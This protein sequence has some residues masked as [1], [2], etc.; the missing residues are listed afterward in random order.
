V[1]DGVDFMAE[2][3]EEE[4]HVAAG[5]ADVEDRESGAGHGEGEIGLV[6]KRLEAGD[7][8][9]DL[10]G[11]PVG[12]GL[13]RDDFRASSSASRRADSARRDG[14]WFIAGGKRRI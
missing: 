6:R 13:G 9:E 2:A 1:V 8:G 14:G 4:A 11:V 3:F 5:G 12:L 10:E 7:V